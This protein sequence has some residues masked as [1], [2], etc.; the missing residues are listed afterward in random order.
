[1]T[2]ENDT[3]K[4]LSKTVQMAFHDLRDALTP[5]RLAADLLRRAD[6][7]DT[8]NL[9]EL[10][11]LIQA[12]VERCLELISSCKQN[13][14]FSLEALELQTWL[15]KELELRQA[16][17]QAANLSIHF[18]PNQEEY[19]CQANGLALSRVLGN[20]LSNAEEVLRQLPEDR[21]VINV[22]LFKTTESIGFEV[23]DQGPGIPREIAGK[24]FDAFV[25][26]SKDG[27][28]Q[29]LGL[30][31]CKKLLSAMEGSIELIDCDRGTKFRVTLKAAEKPATP[32]QSPTKSPTQDLNDQHNHKT[33]LIVDD[34]RA[35]RHSYHRLLTLDGHRV[36][37]AANGQ[38]ALAVLAHEP[39]DFILIDC[40]LP[41]VLGP[42]LFTEIVAKHPELKKAIIFTTGE[43]QNR[44]LIEA[45]NAT[46]ALLLF[47]PFGDADLHQAF[48]IQQQRQ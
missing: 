39:A 3:P 5:I 36:L 32:D 14:E 28:G 20:L 31:I 10:A 23:H 43:T 18:E 40:H 25:T 22:S 21:R 48:A 15:V 4:E 7:K 24:L 1:M 9:A 19:W 45:M 47:K 42:D 27:R 41:D 34:D 30:H 11:D 16:R 13:G 26:T 29:G 37:T 17:N 33:I 8:K 6:P 46:G 44:D 38:E 12:K 35:T 2:E